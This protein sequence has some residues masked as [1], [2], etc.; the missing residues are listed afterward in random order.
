MSAYYLYAI[1]HASASMQPMPAVP[2]RGIDNQPLQWVTCGGLAA[3]ISK[4]EP[5]LM[6]PAHDTD[7]KALHHYEQVVEAVM[8]QAPILPMRFGMVLADLSS[9][10]DLLATRQQPLLANLDHVT[11][12]VE[13][14]LRVLWEPPLTPRTS[15]PYQR[16]RGRQRKPEQILYRQAE[17]LAQKL[18]QALR[19]LAV[20]I[21]LSILQTQHLLLSAAYLVPTTAVAGFHAKVASLRQQYPELALLTSGPWPAYHFLNELEL[22]LAQA[23][24]LP[25]DQVVTA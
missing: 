3:V 10:S 7:P 19:P 12:R 4:W 6:L 24:G 21:R 8:N 9:V 14:G 17:G 23:S 16:R 20:D 1:T 5:A 13:M 22:D 2:T 18:H 25:E 11:G 15:L